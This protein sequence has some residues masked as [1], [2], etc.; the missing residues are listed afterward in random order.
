MMIIMMVM[1]M[2]VVVAVAV[3]TCAGVKSTRC[4]T[5]SHWLPEQKVS[6]GGNV[7]FRLNLVVQTE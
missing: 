7:L 4:L 6:H 2:E 1:M 3:A 5:L